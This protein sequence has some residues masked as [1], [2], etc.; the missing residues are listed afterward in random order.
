M[1]AADPS[2]AWQQTE[3]HFIIRRANPS[4][5]DAVICLANSSPTAANWNRAAYE[6]YCGVGE[7]SLH[8]R[9]PLA[10]FIAATSDNSRGPARIVGFTA[11]SSIQLAIGAECDLENMGV[12][13]TLR[14]RSIGRRLLTAGI[15]WCRAQGG[16]S[17]RLEVRASNVAA[18]ELYGSAG[19]AASGVRR[20]YYA[21]PQEDAIGM[22]LLLTPEAAERRR[23]C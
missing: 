22:C 11:L 7:T 21:E 15:L 4:D 18:L 16:S 20:G 9:R 23:G 14:R 13:A 3:L 10:L 12:E 5:I 17:L 6:A 19:F 1:S 8:S 2:T